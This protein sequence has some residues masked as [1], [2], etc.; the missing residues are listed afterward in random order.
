MISVG[1]Y[2]FGPSCIEE[3]TTYWVMPSMLG[4]ELDDLF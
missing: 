3:A 1:F 4:L 2:V